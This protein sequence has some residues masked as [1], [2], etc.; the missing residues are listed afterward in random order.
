MLDQQRQADE[1]QARLQEQMAKK[2][3]DHAREMTQ[4]QR[5]LLEVLERRPAPV[6]Q[7]AGAQFVFNNRGH[8]PND[9]YE[10]FRKRGP[11]EFTG[12]EDPLAADDRLEYTENIYEIFQCT[13]KQR[14]DL[15]ASIWWK[16]VKAEYRTMADAEAWGNFKTQFSDEYVSTHIKR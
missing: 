9:L 12:Q 16:T 13:G 1:N 11:K 6:A 3:E 4:M 8:D 2:D 7:P 15:A 5:Q 10:R 14:V